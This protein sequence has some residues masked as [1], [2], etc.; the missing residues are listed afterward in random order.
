MLKLKCKLY[1]CGF[2]VGKPW[3]LIYWS[4][5]GWWNTIKY[6]HQIWSYLQYPKLTTD[7]DDS[8]ARKCGFQLQYTVQVGVP[9]EFLREM[10]TEPAQLQ[11]GPSHGLQLGGTLRRVAQIQHLWNTLVSGMFNPTWDSFG[12]CEAQKVD[13]AYADVSWAFCCSV[14]LCEFIESF[15]DLKGH[16]LIDRSITLSRTKA[17][18]EISRFWW[19]GLLVVAWHSALL[20]LKIDHIW[21]SHAARMNLTYENETPILDRHWS[22][23]Q[24]QETY[25]RIYFKTFLVLNWTSIYIDTMTYAVVII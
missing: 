3:F 14:G 24:Y 21:S 20:D 23:I 9:Q 4:I 18:R 11:V 8:W 13:G 15:F 1:P 19:F 6:Y 5:G 12:S 10:H 22:T 17:T 7:S 2:E 25:V 16:D